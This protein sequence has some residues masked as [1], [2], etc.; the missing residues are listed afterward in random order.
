MKIP[1]SYWLKEGEWP[2]QRAVQEQYRHAALQ[3][4]FESEV[5]NFTD[6]EHGVRGAI[7]TTGTPPDYKEELSDELL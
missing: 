3:A 7:N 6:D 2:W 4:G 5:T 1:I